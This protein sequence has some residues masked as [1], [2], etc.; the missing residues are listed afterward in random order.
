MTRNFGP[1]P[2]DRSEADSS[3][4]PVAASPGRHFGA[5]SYARPLAGLA[6]IVIVGIIVAVALALF[7]GNFT[8]TVPVTVVSPRAG[9]VMNPDAKVKMRGVEVGRV[10]S[11]DVRPN[12]QAVLNLEMQPSQM[13]LIPANV[14]VDIASTSVFGAKFVDLIPPADPSPKHL[15]PGAVLQNKDV[16]VEINTVFQ[17]LQNLLSSIDPAKLN[18]TLGAIASAVNGR[19]H[20]IGQTISDFDAFL[21]KQEPSLPALSHDLEAL[22]VVSN[23]YADSAPHL[24]STIDNTITISKTLVEEQQNLDTFLLSSIGLANTGNDVIGTNREVLGDVLHKLVPTTNLL[25]EYHKVLWCGLAGSLENLHVPNNTE[26]M[27]YA[28]VFLGFGTE[29]YRYPSN[30]P[31]VAATG[32]PHC[33]NLPDVPY[34]KAPEFVIA[35]VGANPQEYGNPQLMWNSDALKQLLYGPIDGPPRNVTQ[36]GQPG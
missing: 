28:Q 26:P 21:A 29:R 31:K 30:L 15:Q 32:G 9:L 7:Q 13:P 34:R 14:L 6:T 12:G 4:R 25:N 19:G 8:K 18:E 17:Q 27:I 36:I 5:Q 33:E 10:G 35:D 2:I 23:A 1:G 24:L 22:P 16:T 3:A 20:K 11:I